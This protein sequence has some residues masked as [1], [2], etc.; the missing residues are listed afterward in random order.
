MAMN[1]PRKIMSFAPKED[2]IARIDVVITAKEDDIATIDVVFAAKEDGIATIDVVIAA[3]EDG[4]A[5]IDVDIAAKEDDIAT[6]DVVFAAK[7]DH[8]ATIDVVF[9]AKEDDI[10]T[11]D[12][13]LAA[14]D[15]VFAATD[16]DLD[17]KRAGFFAMLRVCAVEVDESA[18]RRGVC[19]A[20]HGRP[21]RDAGDLTSHSAVERRRSGVH[22]PFPL[23]FTRC[24]PS[25][26]PGKLTIS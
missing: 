12:V 6:I 20:M 4:I 24:A 22:L 9:A 17:R 18:G 23:A 8:I 2:D 7:E 11:I 3:K 15:D 19:A 25:C 14:K 16:D 10:A 1:P 13:V 21:G 5:T 26:P